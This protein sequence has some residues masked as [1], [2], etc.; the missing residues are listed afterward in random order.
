MQ[1]MM[2]S[3]IPWCRSLLVWV[4]GKMHRSVKKLFRLQKSHTKKQQQQQA[5]LMDLLEELGV[6]AM[7]TPVPRGG[8]SHV[9]LPSTLVG[10]MHRDYPREFRLRLGADTAVVREFWRDFLARPQTR[11]W[12]Q[13]HPFLANKGVADLVTTIPCTMHLDA[14]PCTKRQS[15]YCIS[16]TSMLAQGGEKVSVCFCPAFYFFI[17]CFN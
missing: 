13:S 11:A 4:L 14:G 16:W 3:T 15:C 7:L 5:G 8:V 6:L 17:L 9:C 12:A 2:A 10:M 1:W